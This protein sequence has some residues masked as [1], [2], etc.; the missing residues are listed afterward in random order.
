MIKTTCQTNQ[1]EQCNHEFV[2]YESCC[3]CGY[4]KNLKGEVVQPYV[5]SNMKDLND[6]FSKW[7]FEVKEDQHGKPPLAI[8]IFYWFSQR[9]RVNSFEYEEDIKKLEGIIQLKEKE[10]ANWADLGIKKQGRIESLILAL[11]TVDEN[12]IIGNDEEARRVILESLK[13]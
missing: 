4:N 3:Y 1:Q 12:L 8:Q 13:Q 10:R 11:E 9:V 6:E 5:A 2:G 7:Y